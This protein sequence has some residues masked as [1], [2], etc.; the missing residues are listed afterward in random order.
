[1]PYRITPFLYLHP[2]THSSIWRDTPQ[3]PSRLLAIVKIAPAQL[4]R[5]H[6][7]MH[8]HTFCQRLPFCLSHIHI[9]NQLAHLSVYTSPQILVIQ[10]PD[11]QPE[12]ADM[13]VKPAFKLVP[14]T[15]AYPQ[16]ASSW[17]VVAGLVLL[18]L[19]VGSSLQLGLVAEV[20]RPQ[21]HSARCL[22]A[23]GKRG[24]HVVISVH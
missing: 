14:V 6:S 19:T 13:T 16:P 4:S 9:E 12:G 5:T 22:G 11:Q 8:S 7:V 15:V 24:C 17:Q 1:M 18:V 20:R 2:P 3:W 23:Q 21:S 10:D